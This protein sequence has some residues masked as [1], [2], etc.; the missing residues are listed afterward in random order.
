MEKMSLNIVSH[1]LVS[2]FLS[3]EQSFR[4]LGNDQRCHFYQSLYNQTNESVIV[5]CK[6]LF[7]A[8][9]LYEYMSKIQT[10]VFL[11]AIEESLQISTLSQSHELLYQRLQTIT[12][13]NKKPSVIITH[14]LALTRPISPISQIIDAQITLKVDQIIEPYKLK[15]QL[16]KSGY[17]KVMRVSNPFEFAFRGSIVDVMSA[18]NQNPVRIEFFDNQIESIRKF[19][20]ETQHSITAI[21][22][23]TISSAT[24]HL[25][26]PELVETIE[27]KLSPY[28]Q[29]T[30]SV[31]IDKDTLT[32]T[33]HLIIENLKSHIYFDEVA[34]F[35]KIIDPN[36]TTLIQEAKGI[37]VIE[38]LTLALLEL[39]NY[40][41]ENERLLNELASAGQAL[42]DL[43]L[44]FDV[45]KVISKID[46]YSIAID[47]IGENV[48]SLNLERFQHS[49]L[50]LKHL[51]N[52]INSFRIKGYQIVI[53]EENSSNAEFLKN[54]LSQYEMD[55]LITVDIQNQSNC[56]VL[57]KLEQS[58]VD[59]D[60]KIVYFK[61]MLHQKQSVKQKRKDYEFAKD[62]AHIEQL[63]KG[64]YVVHEH[65]GIGRYDGIVT[66]EVQG[67]LR[68][69]LHISYRGDDILYVPTEKFKFVK[70][71][72]AKDGFIPKIN[73]LN[74][75]EWEKTKRRVKQKLS[76]I[77]DD[78]LEVQAQRKKEIGYAFNKDTD[79][80][81]DFEHMFIHE[82][83]IDQ[84]TAID[85]VKKDMESV[86]PMDRLICGDV[87]FGKT[88]VAIRAVFKAV[89]DKKQVAFLCP[90]TILARQHTITLQERFEEF[91][92][93]V[94]NVSRFKS[95]KQIKEILS[96]LA[97]GQ[98]DVIVGTHRLLSS[99]VVF[100]DL[101]LLVIDEEQRFGVV[102]K[103]KMKKLKVNVDILTLSATP[104]PRTLQMSLMDLKAM[105]LLEHPPKN[106]L[107]IQTYVV[108]NSSA[109]IKA[110][111]EKE[112]ARNGKVFFLHNDTQR[113]FSVASQIQ[114]LVETAKVAVVHGKMSAIQIEN[115]IS[116]FLADE[117]NVLVCTTIIETGLD[118][119][120][121]D[122]ILIDN[123]QNFG[124]SQLYQIKG[125]VG[126]RDRVAYAYLLI[127]P[128]KE[129]S[130]QALLRLQAIQEFTR[131]GSSY[132]IAM[133]D[134]AIRGAGDVLGAKQAG[135]I[136]N[137]GIDLYL[138]L[139]QEV[140]DER[141]NITT[142]EPEKQFTLPIDMY[143]PESI[144]IEQAEKL[145]IYQTIESFKNFDEIEDYTKYFK[146]L[147]GKIPISVN[148]IILK[149]KFDLYCQALKIENVGYETNAIKITFSEVGSDQ[150][151]GQALFTIL[152]KT[153]MSAKLTYID[154]KITLIVIKNENWLQKVVNYFAQVSKDAQIGVRK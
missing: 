115:V 1:E 124:L 116:G 135:F 86:L 142:P 111:I 20:L 60:R 6:N 2:K 31:C 13:L 10:D 77:V 69:F 19:D 59:F 26:K 36:A 8:Q 149:K 137:I 93:V 136:D 127:P 152:N 78:L 90:T 148:Q 126:R 95:A 101:G 147:Y 15:E 121:A 96:K 153:K 17:Q 39:D 35:Y 81:V 63:S 151:D 49:K 55:F 104:I 9:Q 130:E 150:M 52:D 117:Y 12:N 28:Y 21:S 70:K 23:V 120:G 56:I 40:Q 46:Y 45:N 22:Q 42:M 43:S 68:D 139:L 50:S 30:L 85:D 134:L 114:D 37:I 61:V 53:C 11:Y 141:Q 107:P 16:L 129:L 58:I 103:E 105:S 57:T 125:R 25:L 133:R 112:L 14:A 128:Q 33:Y 73:A 5:V 34:K 91:G 66:L 76:V 87:G 62:L 106:R 140:K 27:S 108:N 110:S 132:Q 65:Y 71:F 80:Q 67:N 74:S 44:Q 97:L 138:K 51:I 7:Q 3:K 88:E 89:M 4:L 122:T 118:I 32:H 119:E 92:I 100:K 29:K 48:Q 113:I 154:K 99:D 146:D 64:D 123:A 82:L 75:G 47:E 41:N 83:T 131:L 102:H 98:V 84:K 94:E 24:E 143:I 145:E 79:L 109:L 18:D 144:D 54:Y 72:V 38:D